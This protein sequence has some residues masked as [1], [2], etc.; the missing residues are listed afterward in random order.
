MEPVGVAEGV[1]AELGLAVAE[2]PGLM[3]PV[4]VLLGLPE[5]GAGQVTTLSLQLLVSA[6]WMVLVTGSMAT[7]QG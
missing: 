6:I 3:L 7:P 4:A 1:A 5:A 2:E